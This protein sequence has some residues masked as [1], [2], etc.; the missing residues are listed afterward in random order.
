NV[1][2]FV[3]GAIS[4]TCL[5]FSICRTQLP[6]NKIKV[7]ENL[8]D[9]TQS[10]FHSR[11]EE[12]YLPQERLK[13]YIDRRLDSLRDQ[14]CGLQSQAYSATTSA[15]DYRQLFTGLSWAIGRVCFDVR[16]VRAQ[17]IV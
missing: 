11:V 13:V 9:E 7:L 17:V 15:Q 5:V 4:L 12:G 3:A 1:F 6:S 14:A 2:G 10:L 16:E 8:L